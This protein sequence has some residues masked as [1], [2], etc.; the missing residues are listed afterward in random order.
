[1]ADIFT[2][3]TLLC[4]TTRKGLLPSCPV[5]GQKNTKIFWHQSEARTTPTVWYWSG[6]TLS[7]GALSRALDF[8]LPIFFIACLDFP[9]PPRLNSYKNVPS[10]TKFPYSPIQNPY[11]IYAIFSTCHYLCLFQSFLNF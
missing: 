4:K 11:H 1:M 6:K 2:L 5:I 10:K 3:C 9:S 8:S 7:P